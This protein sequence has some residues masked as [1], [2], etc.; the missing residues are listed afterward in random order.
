[1]IISGIVTSINEMLKF[2]LITLGITIIQLI[3]RIIFNK[4]F[5]DKES[6]ARTITFFIISMAV[7]LIE[8][9]TAILGI[10]FNNRSMTM[11]SVVVMLVYTQ[12]TTT[13]LTK[14]LT[15]T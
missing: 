8:L 7:I 15:K 5:K 13:L 2:G 1:M 12:I 6:R 11:Y 4:I 14:D 10:V 9:A 3:I